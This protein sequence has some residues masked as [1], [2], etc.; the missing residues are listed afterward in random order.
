MG[1][2]GLRIERPAAAPTQHPKRAAPCQP[3]AQGQRRLK[4]LQ[5][6]RRR[7]GGGG[8]GGQDLVERGLAG[9]GEV[10]GADEHA[11]AAR[12]DA[13]AVGPPDPVSSVRRRET[14]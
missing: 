7:G 6:R 11:V 2:G 14:E 10:G 13:H 1:W 4:R 8:G 3:K 9:A 12:D 5:S